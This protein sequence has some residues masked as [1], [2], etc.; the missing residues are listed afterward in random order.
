MNDP[1]FVSSPLLPNLK[2]LDPY[3]AQIW[4]NKW[5][6]NHGELHNDLEKKISETL[7]ISYTRLFN[8]G[9]L[10]LVT[11][12]QALNLP[13]HGEVLTTPFTFAATA[14]SISW[15]RLTPVFVDIEPETMTLNPQKIID[16]IS[17]K[18]VAI[19]GV[20]VYGFPCKVFEIDAI[21]KT[22]KL[23]VIYDAAHAFGTKLNGVSIAQFGDI[24]S[25][26][27]HAT[28][29][30]NTIEGGA[31]CCKSDT[32]YKDFYYLRNFGIKNEEE[33]IGIG[34]NG[35]MN[36][37]QAAIGLLNLSLFREEQTKRRA[38]RN[39]Y[40]ALLSDIS[41]IY[42]P[43]IDVALDHSEQYFVMKTSPIHRNLLYDHL[44]TKGIFARKYFYPLLSNTPCY[45]HLPSSNPLLLP[46]ANLASESV[47]CLPF[48]GDLTYD[49]IQLIVNSIKEYFANA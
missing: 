31:L 7:D 43:K 23:P 26:S 1:I 40:L 49:Q 18:T 3:L 34:V 42:I 39:H 30:F 45:Q 47:L 10:S 29:L 12:L 37:I 19:L 24:S 16:H 2:D 13:E 22:H 25:F 44:K 17:S 21:A 6:T 36:E 11:A 38:I 46:E 15:N 41:E 27:F 9:T 8:N 20:H 32:L 48:Y 5:V 33:I 28:K 4:A 14:H 35:K